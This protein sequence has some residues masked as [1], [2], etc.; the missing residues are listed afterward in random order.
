MVDGK[1]FI[2]SELKAQLTIYNWQFTKIFTF[3]A[4][5]AVKLIAWQKIVY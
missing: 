3:L 1:S 5:F 2:V 4:C